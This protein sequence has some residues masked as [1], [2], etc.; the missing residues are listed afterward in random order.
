[1]EPESGEVPPEQSLELTVTAL[2]DDCLKF[3]DKMNV[4]IERGINFTVFLSATG[5]GTT[6]VSE[7]SIHPSVDLGTF[8][9]RG[10]CERQFLLTNK[11]RRMQAL[12][13]VTEGFSASKVKKEEMD[14]RSRDIRDIRVIQKYPKHLVI[15]PRKPLFHIIPEKFVLEPGDSC[16]VTLQGHSKQ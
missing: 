1:M 14:R 10:P 11:G 15:E 8:F 3:T 4:L 5:K 6:I 16:L 2:L 9:S 7:P 12:S 13:W